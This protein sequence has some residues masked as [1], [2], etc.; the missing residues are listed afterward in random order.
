[1]KFNRFK[2]K[3]KKTMQK[4]GLIKKFSFLSFIKKRL[5][6]SRV[7][8]V[9][10]FVLVGFVLI[11]V[12]ISAYFL[13]FSSNEVLAEWWDTNWHYRKAITI[14]NGGSAQTDFQV[15]IDDIDTSDTSKFLGSC[16]D[17]RFTSVNGESIDYWIESGCGTASTDIWI[18]VSSVPAGTSTIYMYYGN[19]NVSAVQSGTN[20]FEFF[21]DFDGSAVD[22]SKWSVYVGSPTVASSLVSFDSSTDSG[23]KSLNTSWLGN[24]S[25]SLETRQRVVSGS[26]TFNF[27]V[28]D[29]FDGGEP[30]SDD[31]DLQLCLTCGN[32]EWRFRDYNEVNY[33]SL[34]K[35]TENVW[36]ITKI[37]YINGT[38]AL[39]KNLADTRSS[40]TKTCFTS[41]NLPTM[42]GFNTI[43]FRSASKTAD[44]DW[45]F[46]RKYVATEPTVAL[47]S[48]EK[49]PGP[50]AYWS[51]DEGYG[52]TAQDRTSNNNDGTITGATWQTEDM[53]VSGK[54]LYF[55]GS[56]SVNCGTSSSLNITSA[57]TLE[58]WVKPLTKSGNQQFIS[59]ST[60]GSGYRLWIMAEKFR[61]SYYGLTGTD[62]VDAS[63]PEINKWY[64]IVGI[65]N[66]DIAS[67]NIK[68]YR[69]GILIDSADASGLNTSNGL[70]TLIGSNGLA[71]SEF[72]NG[73]IDEVKIYPYARSAA[74]IKADYNSGKARASS[75]AGVSAS[76]SSDKLSMINISDGLVGY[77]KMDEVSGNAADSSGNGNAGTWYGT[78]SHYPAGKF[79]NGGGFNGS[80]NYVDVVDNSTLDLETEWTVTAW[81]RREGG[82]D[83]SNYSKIVS[84]WNNYFIATDCVSGKDNKLYGCVGTGSG[85]TCNGGNRDTTLPL[86]EWHFLAFIYSESTQ[87]A[88]L[89][90]DAEIVHTITDVSA[91]AGSSYDLY[92]G[93][94]YDSVT[95]QHFNGKMD[96]V[97][98]YNRALSAREIQQLYEYAPGPV[99]H[100]KMDEKVLGNS[101]TLYDISGN[102]NNG[103]T[104]YGAN[105]TGMDCTKLGKYGGGCEF[106]GVDDYVDFSQLI[107]S[108]GDI[109]LTTWVNTP[110]TTNGF[111]IGYEGIYILTNGTLSPY[112]GG[113]NFGGVSN[114]VTA[115]QWTHVAVIW[116]NLPT[117]P[118]MDVYINGVFKIT[119]HSTNDSSV[120]LDT[121]GNYDGLG[122][123]PYI[124]QIDD[125]RIYNYARTQKQILE[126]MSARGGS[127]LG[128]NAAVAYYKFDEGYGTSAKD[129]SIHGN[130]G[131]ITG[132]DWTNAGKFGKALSFNGST[133]YVN[134]GDD[135]EL[136]M[137]DKDFTF[138]A[139]INPTSYDPTW[140]TFLSGGTGAA[141]LG[142]RTSSGHLRLTKVNISDAPSSNVQVPLDTWSHVAA[143][144]DSH[145]SSNNLKYYINGINIATVTYD[146]DFDTNQATKYIG[147]RSTTH[148]FD[149]LIDEVK[150]YN[151]ALTEEEIKQ[152]YNQGKVSVM[153]IVGG[154]GL[155]STSSA[156]T[157]EYCIPGSSDS[158]DPPVAEWNFDEKTGDYAYDT[159]GNGNTGTLTNMEVV[160]WKSAG[161][162]HSGACLD[163]D[164]ENEKVQ[165]T[166]LNAGTN[167]TVSFWAKPT[168]SID[169][170]Y[171]M[172]SGTANGIYITQTYSNYRVNNCNISVNYNFSS[173]TLY[174]ITWT[175][176]NTTGSL[177]IN[178]K[179]V[180]SGSCVTATT[181]TI[182]GYLGSRG[183]DA[184]TFNGKIDQVRIYDYARTSA[185]IAWDYN[186]GKP[187][188]HW[189]FDEGQGTTLY[190][191]SDNDNDGTLSLGSLGQIS[192]GSV[193]V[194][195]NTAWYNGCEGKQNYSLNFDGSDDYIDCENPASL[196]FGTGDFSVCFWFKTSTSGSFMNFMDTG[197]R[198]V[199]YG[200]FFIWQ[201]YAGDDHLH[202]QYE[203]TD[204]GS[205]HRYKARKAS[206]FYYDGS[207]HF[208]CMAVDRDYS[209]GIPRLFIDGIEDTA[210]TTYSSG[211]ATLINVSNSA[212]RL[213]LTL[214]HPYYTPS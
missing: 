55:D 167:N 107:F 132:A 22:T 196:N 149:G 200:N 205:N 23:I 66:P 136:N 111:P 11:L 117:N 108:K 178:G 194:N 151:Y 87:T 193:K 154:D 9:R 17:I 60:S 128:G 114:A 195:A 95:D 126:D 29:G 201:G 41:T 89:Y 96:E 56:N 88:N 147:R 72:F 92:F 64:H 171:V 118:D 4:I 208:L 15:L 112:H 3:I 27:G 97:R 139:W 181:D 164:G 130:N 157:A 124:G 146:V 10:K 203:W 16:Q 61:F 82:C 191:E 47:Q 43:H 102:E 115:N 68:I 24:G 119:T 202:V 77:W 166:G 49:G 70:G 158:C 90:M 37:A 122:V 48:E 189:R 103:T 39:A 28:S 148:Y 86:N 21:D 127:A 18:K 34:T 81:V 213:F 174:H 182:I 144:F 113:N 8:P 159:S 12:V 78:G 155:G 53:C 74:Q 160:D 156:G 109:T 14:T 35:D 188:A 51:F 36:R 20:T 30:N 32:I 140:R 84:K 162:C 133:D 40:E 6:S 186:K 50:V 211:D 152:E 197:G 199:G 54:C 26:N 85:H 120:R 176:N 57:I 52:T 2:K 63:I 170:Y 65:Y 80:D 209:S 73:F 173:D 46:V 169:A 142:L 71:S 161:E 123:L 79:G 62:A 131:T 180:N 168:G 83:T 19:P 125:V 185:Q 110:L 129:S 134:M 100:W 204:T 58:A 177:Y 42:T 135:D 145:S 33:C 44:V 150:V 187:V 31:E 104:Y 137:E 175:R 121:F 141:S 1:M 206:T 172:G 106:D 76:L 59:K 94:P 25:Y 179:L 153:G 99:G 67:D 210:G 183:T 212:N 207:W 138:G 105:T 7:G 184:Y 116:K 5:T 75:S 198:I 93:V 91:T 45:I 69:N 163:F 38:S 192:A 101:Q 98:I 143:V 13:F 190:D 165:I 214:Q